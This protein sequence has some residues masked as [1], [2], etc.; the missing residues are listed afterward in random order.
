MSVLRT[1]KLLALNAGKSLG[2]FRFLSRSDWRRNQLL[3]LA[4][5]GVSMDDEHLWNSDLFVTPAYFRSRM[6][7]LKDYGCNVL[8]LSEALQRLEKGT[9]P[10][11]SV[12]LTF[13]DGGCD[14]YHRAFPILREFGWPA[15]VYLTSY[16]SNYNRPVFDVMCSYLLWKGRGRVIDVDGLLN[17]V[18]SLDLRSESQ[19]QC[20][21]MAIRE[22]TRREKFSAERKDKLLIALAERLSVDYQAILSQRLLHLLSLNECAELAAQGVDIQLHTHRHH[23]PKTRESFLLELDE[24]R[25]FITRF[26]KHPQHFSY[27]H[28]LYEDCFAPW[29]SACEVTSATTCD[30]G[31]VDNRSDIYKL[32]RVVDTSSLQLVELEGWISGFSKFLPRKAV[33]EA[34]VVP[35]FYY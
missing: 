1:A 23:S 34:I 25:N 7:A 32:P 15:T 12:V 35:P 9:L 21:T 33:Q 30:P 19:R 14:F 5:H 2:V 6:Q 11:C 10:E 22:F 17:D 3:I 4:Y 28:G 27:P 13:D 18:A 26:T 20:A 16:Y 24:N 31:L 8:P 29:F